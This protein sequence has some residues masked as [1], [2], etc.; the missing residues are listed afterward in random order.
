MRWLRV[1]QATRWQ[2]N[3]ELVAQ[4]TSAAQVRVLV[5]HGAKG[6]SSLAASQSM[7]VE[8][9][10]HCVDTTVINGVHWGTWLVFAAIMSHFLELGTELELL[11]S[12][13]NVDLT[14]DQVD[15]LSTQAHPSSDLLASYVLPLVAHGSSN[16]TGRG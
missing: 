8:L 3:A 9:L 13:C 2:T 15:A 12:G 16:N 7:A 14:E 1:E 5:L 4:R 10:E 11:G 6:L